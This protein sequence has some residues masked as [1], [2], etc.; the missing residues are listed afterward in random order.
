MR[1]EF[2]TGLIAQRRNQVPSPT[3][4]QP[5]VGRATQMGLDAQSHLE[6]NDSHRFF[7]ATGDLLVTGPTG[8]NVNDLVAVLVS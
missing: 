7:D 4:T 1:F 3:V 6:N 2:E 5:T 8:S